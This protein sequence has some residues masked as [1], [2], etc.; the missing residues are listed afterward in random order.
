M[1][2]S[3]RLAI[4][5]CGFGFAGAAHAATLIDNSTAG[6]YNAGIGRSL[7][8][9]NPFG[10]SHFMFPARETGLNADFGPDDEPDLSKAF[11]ALGNWLADPASP[12]G[13]WS[14]APVAI[15]S[16]WVRHSETAIIYSLDGGTTG[17]ANVTGSFGVDN[18][19]FVW[20]NG[21][22]VGGYMRPG[23]ANDGEWTLSLGN[24]AAGT[25]HLQILREDHG[26]S[27]GY[28]VSVTGD[29]LRATRDIVSPAPS[30]LP[31]PVSLPAPV[32]LPASALL[33]MAGMGGLAALGR[34]K[35]D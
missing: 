31:A 4:V 14:S 11:S 17:L 1:H 13:T 2:F 22:F 34:R 6:L 28:S 19:L 18:S 27:T 10:A 15:P 25:N 8:L 29:S 23:G 32:P 35:S 7:N 24:L 26:V 12:G 20:L 30:P 3:K 21:T 9:T 5:V 16:T 33:L